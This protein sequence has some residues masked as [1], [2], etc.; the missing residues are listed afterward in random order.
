MKK[1]KVVTKK[2]KKKKKGVRAVV[3]RAVVWTLGGR[4]RRVCVCE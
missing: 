1:T 2:K 3:A 4:K